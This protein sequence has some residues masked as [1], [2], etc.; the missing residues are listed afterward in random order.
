MPSVTALSLSSDK[1]TLTLTGSNYFTT[2]YA[3][4]VTYA[5]IAADSIVV[6]SAT[7]LSATWN[8]GL[9]LSNTA[10]YPVIWFERSADSHWATV[11]A[12][13]TNTFTLSSIDSNV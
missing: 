1:L 12:N 6:N 10:L 8:K 7:S 2:G 13:F 5:S 4:K 11:T 9:P 3:A